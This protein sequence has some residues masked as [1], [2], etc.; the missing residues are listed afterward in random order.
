MFVSVYYKHCSTC[1]NKKRFDGIGN[2]VI[3]FGSF[4]I[5]HAVLKDYICLFL[6]SGYFTLHVIYFASGLLYIFITIFIYFSLPMCKYCCNV[7]TDWLKRPK[8]IGCLD[9]SETTS[10]NCLLYQ[11]NNWSFLPIAFLVVLTKLS[12]G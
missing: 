7:K 11:K 10:L 4:C 8:K 1:E 2:K 5:S 9:E 12:C 6:N 3:W